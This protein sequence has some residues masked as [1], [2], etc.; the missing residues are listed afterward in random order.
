MFLRPLVHCTF[1]LVFFLP[2][3]GSSLQGS[4]PG[5]EIFEPT[6]IIL[7]TDQRRIMHR[8][9]HTTALVF[10]TTVFYTGTWTCMLRE[11]DNK[12]TA[13]WRISIIP[14][15]GRPI[16]INNNGRRACL[17]L[18]RLNNAFLLRVWGIVSFLSKPSVV[19][20]LVQLSF[21]SRISFTKTSNLVIY[22]QGI[23]QL[24]VWMFW[25]SG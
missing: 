3:A 13:S 14:Q 2:E 8:K 11:L 1:R 12:T 10:F 15:T 7:N 25:S 19:W 16:R 17:G 6:N 9:L 4:P 18:E 20:Y 5:A 24:I 21:T 22:L 23:F